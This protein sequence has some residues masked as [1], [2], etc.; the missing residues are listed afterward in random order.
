MRS[1]GGR[2]QPKQTV[3]QAGTAFLNSAISIRE[4]EEQEGE[5]W[6]AT[7]NRGEGQGREEKEGLKL[8]VAG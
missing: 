8:M 3:C 4:Q 2:G 6:G 1:E 7:E 5:E